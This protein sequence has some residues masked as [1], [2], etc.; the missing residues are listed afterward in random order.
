MLLAFRDR[1]GR[2]ACAGCVCAAVP[3]PL[4]TPHPPPGPGPV[5]SRPG[6]QVL[7]IQRIF[8]PPFFLR[9]LSMFD[10]D[11]DGL[12]DLTEVMGAIFSVAGSPDTP[13]TLE[14]LVFD[15]YDEGAAGSGPSTCL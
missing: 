1:E 14:Q 9:V 8:A 13:L 2:T 12:V 11:G 15:V 4:A 3:V 10:T 7:R 6:Q 5:P